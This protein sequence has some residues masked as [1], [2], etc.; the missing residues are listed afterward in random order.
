MQQLMTSEK[1]DETKDIID[2]QQTATPEPKRRS[3]KQMDMIEI[4]I[5]ETPDQ[6]SASPSSKKKQVD[7]EAIMKR[8]IETA[9]NECSDMDH[10]DIDNDFGDEEEEETQKEE[11]DDDIIRDDDVVVDDSDDEFISSAP[12]AKGKKRSRSI[13]EEEAEQEKEE[14][15]VEGDGG[16]DGKEVTELPKKVAKKLVVKKTGGGVGTKV[17]SKAAASPAKSMNGGTKTTKL[18]VKAKVKSSVTPSKSKKNVTE[19]VNKTITKSKGS[20]ASNS[21]KKTTGL[22]RTYSKKDKVGKTTTSGAST[23]TPKK[24]GTPKKIGTVSSSAKK[25]PSSKK[26]GTSKSNNSVTS[27]P[28]KKKTIVKGGSVTKKSTVA[29]GSATKKKD[30]P[31]KKSGIAK[32]TKASGGA[33]SAR[34]RKKGSKKE[35]DEDDGDEECEEEGNGDISFDA[36]EDDEEENSQES[37]LEDEDMITPKMKGAIIGSVACSSRDMNMQSLLNH[38]V[39]QLGKYE[40]MD[41]SADYDDNTPLRGYVIGNDTK[42]GWGVL[43][44]IANNV[45][46]VSEEWV[47]QSISDGKWHDLKSF[48]SLKFGHSP[49]SIQENG[50]RILEGMRVGVCLNDLKEA[51]NVR[52]LITACGGRVAETRVDIVVNDTDCVIEGGANVSKKWL[53]DSVEAAV[54]LESEP[55]AIHAKAAD[56]ATAD[57]HLGNGGG[58]PGENVAATA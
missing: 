54:A 47:T 23:S 26:A 39:R 8:V 34:R 29:N 36:D 42:R 2:Q 58:D 17:T 15:E 49:R 38:A 45:P 7:G 20:T 5:E 14:E 56:T 53:A 32:V 33:G 12:V 46:L 55:Y 9:N 10:D 51:A 19:Q 41:Y 6:F 28:T 13:V 1:V 44:A 35:D 48:S 25:I 43:R 37:N 27:T 57:G 30:T 31:K 18:K 50:Q 4:E 22:V 24:N 11:A 40:L 16:N 52:K 3:T 21:T